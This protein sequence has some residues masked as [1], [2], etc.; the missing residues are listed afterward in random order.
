MRF[1]DRTERGDDTTVCAGWKVSLSGI[2][3]G[4]CRLATGG[5]SAPT[6]GRKWGKE[7]HL[8][9][10]KIV[11]TWQHHS[12]KKD[13]SVKGELGHFLRSSY[14]GKGRPGRHE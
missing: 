4:G 13:V 14:C 9:S 7:T 11:V 2:F 5:I 10:W 8:I 3:S 6:S 12:K 1:S